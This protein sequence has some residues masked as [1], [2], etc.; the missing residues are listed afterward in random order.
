MHLLPEKGIKHY[1]GIFDENP[2]SWFK[3]KALRIDQASKVRQ[4]P[5]QKTWSVNGLE[6]TPETSIYVTPT[7]INLNQYYLW[8]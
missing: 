7:I 4:H 8:A 2:E 6:T 5:T 1:K 3:F